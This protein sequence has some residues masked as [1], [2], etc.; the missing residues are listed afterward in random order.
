[1]TTMTP[2]TMNRS[3]RITITTG[4]VATLAAFVAGH[5]LYEA[6]SQQAGYLI[7]VLA[8]APLAFAALQ[9]W[10]KSGETW[11]KILFWIVALLWATMLFIS[12][13]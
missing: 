1:M 6:G 9:V 10:R 2:G 13:M 7:G 12:I 8:M 5:F 11:A 3:A 4:V